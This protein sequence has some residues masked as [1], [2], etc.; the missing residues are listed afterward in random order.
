MAEA[1]DILLALGFSATEIEA[2]NLDV[3]AL[4]DSYR[5]KQ[6]EL[7]KNDSSF[8]KPIQD[9]ERAKVQNTN[10]RKLKQIFELSADDIK[11]KTFEEIVDVA[12]TKSAAAKNS[13]TDEIQK[14]LIEANKKL[15]QYEE[16]ILPA[17]E[18]EVEE[19]VKAYKIAE[20]L[21]KKVAAL[22]LSI[23]PE[24]AM[25][26]LNDHLSKSN[27]LELDENGELLILDKEGNRVTDEK[28]TKFFSVEEILEGAASRYKIKKESNAGESAG[29]AKAAT[30][31]ATNTGA[32][33][34]GTY[35]NPNKAGTKEWLERRK[36]ERAAQA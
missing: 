23:D 24:A 12:K 30:T 5:S 1:K 25:I 28:K 4:V 29:A 2:E 17:K 7:F 13:N 11:D 19:K 20:K 3:D 31:G 27:K 16:E 18:R 34:A 6:K 22:P 8:V 15:K 32:A 33:N 26:I 35:A 9:A 10:E 21:T 36:E 14:E